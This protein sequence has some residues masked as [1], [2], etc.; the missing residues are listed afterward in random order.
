MTAF[1]PRD[2]GVAVI[3]VAALLTGCS[4]D[5]APKAVSAA[6]VNPLPQCEPLTNEQIQQ[7]VHADT[8]TAHTTPPVCTWQAER[9]GVETDLTFTFTE[10]DSLQQIWDRAR[11]DGYDTEHL[12]VTREAL[13]TTITATGIYVRDPRDLGYCQV[14]AA[15]NGTITWRVQNPSHTPAPDPCAIALELATLT[16][17][18]S[19]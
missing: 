15:L 17:D 2:A 1:S 6:E 18:L 9:A 16:I 4:S 19:P 8:L 12:T 3:A 5:P 13:G 11:E 7:A 14:S 10:H